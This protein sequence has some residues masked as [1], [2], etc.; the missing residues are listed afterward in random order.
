[1]KIRDSDNV[2]GELPKGWK[3]VKVSEVCNVV[4]GGSPRPAGDPRYY[5]G[6][7]PF[8]KVADVTK[9]ENVYLNSF[10]YTITEAGLH[11]TRKI[12]PN[13][14]LLSNSG[15][16]LGVPK[17]CMIDETMNDGIAA[18]CISIIFG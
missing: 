15:A 1:M 14:L 4:R 17:V 9:D 6:Y 12:S 13:T 8:L 2:N 18:F 10:Q 7:I 16:T 5:G 11:K 3:W